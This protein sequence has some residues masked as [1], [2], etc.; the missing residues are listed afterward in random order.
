MGHKLCKILG[1]KLWDTYD[2]VSDIFTKPQLK[3]KVGKWRDDPCLPVWRRGPII[4]LGKYKDRYTPNGYHCVKVGKKTLSDGRV[5]D[6]YESIQHKMPVKCGQSV[7]RR[8]IRKKLRKYYLGWIPATINLPMFFAF[9]IFNWD[10]MWKTKWDDVRY[11]YPPQ[12]T[13]VLFGISFSWWLVAPSA[14]T[15]WN[16]YPNNDSYWETILEYLYG[17]NGM[18]GNLKRCIDAYCWRTEMTDEERNK[19]NGI[20]E[21]MKSLDYESPE[22]EKL[23]QEMDSIGIRVNTLRCRPEYLQDKYLDVF[24]NVLSEFKVKYFDK[25]NWRIE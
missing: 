24:Y 20:L 6:N 19:V 3:F 1:I 17:E 14:S 7:W 10:I 15:D 11:E 21:Q 8:D 16:G 12:F 22:Y 13:I 25:I 2:K 9:H 18:K 4:T 23:R 5:L